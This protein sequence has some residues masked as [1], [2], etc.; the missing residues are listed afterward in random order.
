MTATR[1]GAGPSP[2]LSD[3]L[4]GQLMEAGHMPMMEFY[5]EGYRQAGASSGKYHPPITE[6]VLVFALTR[7]SEDAERTVNAADVIRAKWTD[8]KAEVADLRARL[9]RSELSISKRTRSKHYQKA[10]SFSPH[11]EFIPECFGNLTFS[12]NRR[13]LVIMNPALINGK[14]IVLNSIDS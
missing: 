6:A 8:S 14:N 4:M 10:E 1:T 7:L 12:A 3:S 13:T 11:L 9:R 2:K 5:A